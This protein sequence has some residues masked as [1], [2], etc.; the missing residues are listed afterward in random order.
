MEQEKE[1]KAKERYTGT[2][3]KT[4]LQG[5]LVDIGSQKPAFIHISQAVKN[6]DPKKQI[7]SINEVLEVGQ[8]LD[9]WVKRVRKDRIE[10]TM[11]E[12][13]ALEWREIKPDMTVKGKVVR[14]ET[15]GAFVEIGAERP[16]LIHIS[17]LA[18]SYVRTPGEV[19]REGDEVEAKVLEVN[20][21]KKQIKLSIKA[22]QVL[23]E[24]LQM[25]E[26]PASKKQQEEEEPKEPD[27]TAMEIALRSA[28]E[29][30]E[31]SQKEAAAK[32]SR[33]KQGSTSEQDEILSRTL[34][35]KVGEE[36]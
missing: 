18:H 36:S 31:G 14:L 26:P 10:L 24:N 7:N 8:K 32:K 25:P 22:L 20:R 5:A 16:G 3:L 1:F 4:T 19:V 6:D 17:E 34:E 13:L 23:P 29:K 12:P 21:R 28:M 9:F 33:K 35:N 2:V 27:L 30:S 11:K 15:F